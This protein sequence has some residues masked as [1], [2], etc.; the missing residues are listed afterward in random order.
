MIK[1]VTLYT[2]AIAGA[3]ITGFPFVWMLST[4]LKSAS[5]AIAPSL[6]LWPGELH[7]ENFVEAMNAAP[8]GRYLLNSFFVAITTTVCVVCTA[9]AAGFAF[10]RLEF[11]F[12]R[13]LLM[14]VIGTMAVPIE[15]VIIPN[16]IAINRLGWYDTYIA[17]I[18]PWA[19]SAF[20]VFLMTQAFRSLPQ[21][22]FDAA[23]ADGCGPLR[24]LWYVGAPLVRPM[25]AVAGVLAFLVSYN[26]LLWPVLVTGSEEMRVAQ[27]GLTVFASEAGTRFHLL[28]CASAIVMA[29][30]LALYFAAQRTFEESA[31]GA[32]I[33]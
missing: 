8:F 16:F 27:V 10:A 22:Y 7:F 29:P 2:L 28:M 23:L 20:S 1:R 15:M 21:A 25:M 31:L 32:G 17:L 30:T 13:A 14:L 19:A 6:V 33:K 9:T 4:G 11:P 24:T 3:L 5:D 26:A 18:L 12:R